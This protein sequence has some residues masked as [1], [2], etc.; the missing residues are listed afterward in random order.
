M[1]ERRE[2]DVGSEAID[3]A[4]L[5]FQKGGGTLPVVAQH[6]LTGEVLMLGYADRGAMEQSLETG[7]LTFHSRSRG[8]R[9]TKGE[10][11]GNVLR[12]IALHADCDGDAVLA[13]VEP[14]GPTCHTGRRSCFGAAP[15]LLALADTLERRRAAS[16]SE[17]Y[18]AR[19]LADRNQRLK[20]LGEEAVE[21]AVACAGG[22]PGRV[23]DEAADL[24]Y[25]A[26]V[27]CLAEG[28]TL[29]GVLR[30]LAERSR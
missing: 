25:H 13:L 8:R 4:G 30:T 21:L 20:K 26:L 2:D 10:T 15:T 3:V 7:L 14:A 18:T 22:E 16:P 19:L 6:H 29:D 24:L 28:V 17:S 11:S 12:V 1:T 9:W 5:D 27:A 23:R